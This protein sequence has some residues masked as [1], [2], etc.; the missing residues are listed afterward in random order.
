LPTGCS[1][2]PFFQKRIII[3]FAEIPVI[4]TLEAAAVAG[5]VLAHLMYRVMDGI[6]IELLGQCCQLF[7]AGAGTM[8]G[9]YAHLQI[10]L[11]AVREDFAQKLCELGSMLCFFPGVALEVL[12]NLRLAFP[13]SLAAHGQIHA[14]LGAFAC[15]VHAQAFDD[16]GIYVL[17]NTDAVLVSKDQIARLLSEFLSRCLADGALSRRGI[18]LMNVTTDGADK[19]FHF[20]ILLRNTQ[21]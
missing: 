9:I 10:L 2:N 11:G 3:L 1:G 15:E 7:L 18:P 17:G 13:I 4:E 12:G 5:F 21:K 8:L 16:A 6:Q 14:P 20:G 19:F